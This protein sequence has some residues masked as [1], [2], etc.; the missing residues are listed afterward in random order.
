VAL[1]PRDTR[2]GDSLQIIV[3]RSSDA[4]ARARATPPFPE[5]ERAG[6]TK[7]LRNRNVLLF[8]QPDL[9]RRIRE[10]ARGIFQTLGT[11]R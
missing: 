3:F 7:V 4:A 2:V 8:L 5:I 1:V 9:D 11:E 6:G 10:K